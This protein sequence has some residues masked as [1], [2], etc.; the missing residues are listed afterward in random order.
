MFK[1][2]THAK[3]QMH[4]KLCVFFATE[5]EN[6]NQRLYIIYILSIVTHLGYLI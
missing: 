4:I 2:H 1:L 5:S 3:K 6:K